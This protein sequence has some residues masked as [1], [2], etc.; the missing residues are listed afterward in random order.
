MTMFIGGVYANYNSTVNITSEQSKN[1]DNE[2]Q[3]LTWDKIKI[4]GNIDPKQFYKIELYCT[5]G[6][7]VTIT[8][9][10][11]NGLKENGEPIFSSFKYMVKSLQIET[12]GR[13]ACIQEHFREW[14]NKFISQEIREAYRQQ[15][16]L[17]L[18]ALCPSC[19]QRPDIYREWKENSW[20]ISC[21]C[22]DL[23]FTESLPQD[24]KND[25]DGQYKFIV[26]WYNLNMAF[27]T[28]E[29]QDEKKPL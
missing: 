6:D 29:R 1:S 4:K 13:E 15:L 20:K 25:C 24:L 16:G 9:T 27:A 28:V 18:P 3:L 26:N 5:A 12:S 2:C 8:I 19:K 14:N 17:S 7:V 10:L 23:L 22:K 11:L 21:A